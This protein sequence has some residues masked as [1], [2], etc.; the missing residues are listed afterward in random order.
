MDIYTLAPGGIDAPKKAGDAGY[1]LR[2]A[3]G[4]IILP[5][6]QKII[7]TGVWL[8]IPP[9]HVGMICDRSS[10]AAMGLSVAG[11]IIDSG[12][13]GEVKVM[14]HN[15]SFGD[16]SIEAGTRI[17]QLLILPVATPPLVVVESIAALGQS[18]RGAGGFGSTGE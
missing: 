16:C 5:D 9:G 8:A 7:A 10:I 6:T 1:D 2:A 11:G 14:L 3:H 4:V 15:R 13:R 12:Y 18:E 17:A